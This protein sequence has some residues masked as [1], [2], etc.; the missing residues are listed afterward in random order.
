MNP[1]YSRYN[2]HHH[3]TTPLT[4]PPETP[5][6]I[7]RRELE[8]FMEYHALWHAM[9]DLVG[10]AAV[11]EEAHPAKHMPVEA[12]VDLDRFF[13]RGMHAVY[14]WCCELCAVNRVLRVPCCKAC[15]LNHVVMETVCFESYDVN[16]V[17]VPPL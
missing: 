14:V 5:Q 2:S 7:G 15:A 13:A 3:T 10:A 6:P 4:T 17:Q 1:F 11:A 16:P 9:L 12:H 8:L